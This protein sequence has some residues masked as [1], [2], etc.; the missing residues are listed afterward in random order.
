MN[1]LQVRWALPALAALAVI[2]CNQGGSSLSKDEDKALRNNL[3]REL[4]P[5]EIARMNSAPAAGGA[6][7]G[8]GGSAPAEPPAGKGPR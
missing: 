5:D 7:K 1:R 3:S 6:G 2:G 4:T 8:E